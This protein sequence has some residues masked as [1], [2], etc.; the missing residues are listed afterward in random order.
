MNLFGDTIDRLAR[1]AEEDS[2]VVVGFSGGKDSLVCLDLATRCFKQVAAYF[3][4]FIPGLKCCQLALEAARRQWNVPIVQLSA[5][6]GPPLD[7]ERRLV[8]Q[9]A[10][11]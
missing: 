9:R 8:L 11:D 1:A 3:M 7:S 4:Y 2:R 10:G 5:L 6:G